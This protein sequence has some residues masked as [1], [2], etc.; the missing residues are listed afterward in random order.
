M[1]SSPVKIS[2]LSFILYVHGVSQFFGNDYPPKLVQ[3]SNNP[4]WF[5]YNST[6][7]QYFSVSF[8][9]WSG[10][11][12]QENKLFGNCRC[13]S[14]IKRPKKVKQ[15]ARSVAWP[16]GFWSGST[17]PGVPCWF[18]TQWVRRWPLYPFAK[19]PG[20]GTRMRRSWQHKGNLRWQYIR[21]SKWER[22]YYKSVNL[23]SCLVKLPLSIILYPSG[24]GLKCI[25]FEVATNSVQLLPSS[26]IEYLPVGLRKTGS[27]VSPWKINVFPWIPKSQDQESFT[28]L[29][30]AS[31]EFLVFI[32][33]TSNKLNVSQRKVIV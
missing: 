18:L 9:K 24:F 25:C 11:S 5:R 6:H 30:C 16:P 7:H 32:G 1:H 8:Y 14:K 3:I 29:L 22:N 12:F 10:K 31:K 20:T 2:K 15:H 13:D 17:L 27:V 28:V 21:D 4:R 19:L 23:K 26:R 33:Y